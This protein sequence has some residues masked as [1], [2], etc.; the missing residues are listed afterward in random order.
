MKEK[1]LKELMLRAESPRKLNAA[2]LKNA[3]SRTLL[4]GGTR[5]RDSFHVYLGADARL[6][7]VEYDKDG[8]LVRHATEDELLLEEYEPSRHAYPEA[9]DFEFCKLLQDNG[10]HP[11]FLQYEESPAAAVFYGKLLADL[12]AVPESHTPARIRTTA[13][14]VELP[15][16]CVYR[17]DRDK[18][19]QLTREMHRFANSH[20]DRLAKLHLYG[21][22][23]V[24]ASLESFPALIESWLASHS[25][26]HQY[27]MPEAVKKRLLK[28]ATQQVMRRDLLNIQEEQDALCAI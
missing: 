5:N 12:V 18:R 9:C 11:N 26:V 25:Q 17:Q 23:D 3:V 16:D 28:E 7:L 27:V 22:K 20:L 19:T 4:F 14:E 8:F 21:G 24:S 2:M 10:V 13:G 1:E 15:V 6:H